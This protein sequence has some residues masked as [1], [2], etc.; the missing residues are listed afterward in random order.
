ERVLS[1]FQKQSDLLPSL[2]P[3]PRQ[4]DS[5]EEVL[6]G[7]VADD[8]LE[9]VQPDASAFGRTEALALVHGPAQRGDLRVRASEESVVAAEVGRNL[10][11]RVLTRRVA[12]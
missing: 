12:A 2:D 7:R 3:L 9:V 1:P 10:S 11:R 6:R 4:V 5:L 8:R